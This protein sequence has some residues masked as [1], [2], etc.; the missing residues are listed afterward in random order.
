M[1]KRFYTLGEL[2]R[3]LDLDT[4]VLRAWEREFSG[5]RPEF[6]PAGY[7]LYQQSDIAYCREIKRLLQD[8]RLPIAEAKKALR[9]WTPA[10]DGQIEMNLSSAPEEMKRRMQYRKA[11][12]R[13]TCL[14]CGHYLRVEQRGIMADKCD[15]IGVTG[16]ESTDIKSW[17]TCIKHKKAR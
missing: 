17:F 5:L 6:T 7:R 16:N 4:H 15:L 9:S 12:D 2:S 14:Q 1:T 8:E 11:T 3:I 10:H 13:N